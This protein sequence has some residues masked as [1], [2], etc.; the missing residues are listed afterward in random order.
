MSY[1]RLGDGRAGRKVIRAV[2][3]SVGRGHVANPG[4]RPYP[5]PHRYATTPTASSCT[6]GDPSTS[7]RPVTAS[8]TASCSMTDTSASTCPHKVSTGGGPSPDPGVP[9]VAPDSPSR[10]TASW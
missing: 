5:G 10:G 4:P 2:G 9:G 8:F 6:A 7:A 3:E 1:G